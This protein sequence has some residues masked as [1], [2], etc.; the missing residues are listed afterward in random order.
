[1][2]TEK[3]IIALAEKKI[4][5][6]ELLLN[7]GF[8]DDA[9]YIGGYSFELLLKAKICKVLGV[10]DFFETK[11]EFIRPESWKVFK[12]H[13]YKTLLVFAGLYSDLKIQEET[14][15]VFKSDWRAILPW[16]ESA[17]YINEKT[18][19][20]VMEFLESLKNMIVWL[21]QYL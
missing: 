3:E 14:N 9:Y 18:Q 16:D 2:R 4:V 1:M 12:V 11:N 17:R 10:P 7:N 6:A 15:P 13:D 5:A 8:V 21:K 20:D 19:T